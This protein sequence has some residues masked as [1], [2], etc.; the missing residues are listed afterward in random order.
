MPDLGISKGR[1]GFVDVSGE[2]CAASPREMSP[3]WIMKPGIK[4]W[5]GVL[6]YAP[7]AQRARKF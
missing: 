5:N 2:E 1:T 4:R 6:L 7:V 3:P